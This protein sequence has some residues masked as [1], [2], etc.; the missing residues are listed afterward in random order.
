MEIVKCQN[1]SRKNH[2]FLCLIFIFMFDFIYVCR[3]VCISVVLYNIE[4]CCFPYPSF[5]YCVFLQF[6]SLRLFW[7]IA[8]LISSLHILLVHTFSFLSWHTGK[9]FL[10]LL[11]MTI[12]LYMTFQLYNINYHHFYIHAF[13]Y[14]FIC[15]LQCCKVSYN[16]SVRYYSFLKHS[17]FF[18]LGISHTSAPYDV[19]LSKII[20]MH[21]FLLFS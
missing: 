13:S 2:F 16:C 18:C 7:V 3:F 9:H 15:S 11:Y 5:H 1:H 8:E 4:I 10:H 20:C 21:L 12:P 6:S 19:K 17:I 14:C